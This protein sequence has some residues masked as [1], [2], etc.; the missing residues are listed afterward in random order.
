MRYLFLFVVL[1]STQ[2][3]A[4]SMK[5]E[6]ASNP[7]REV[8]SGIYKSPS[9]VIEGLAAVMEYRELELADSGH[10]RE[11]IIGDVS[12]P[13][14]SRGEWEIV[15]DSIVL[16]FGGDSR[17]LLVCRIQENGIKYICLLPSDVID[18]DSVD[19]GEFLVKGLIKDS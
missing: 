7:V 14:E 13:E 3:C 1:L 18:S 2:A 11:L 12:E 10:F 16:S 5:V 15:G 8:V 9:Q 19:R 17:R 4:R 6:I